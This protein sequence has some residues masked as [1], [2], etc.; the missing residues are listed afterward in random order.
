MRASGGKLEAFLGEVRRGPYGSRVDD[1]ESHAL[2][3][4]PAFDGFQI[5]F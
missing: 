3:P 1:I 2:D 4:V 5:R